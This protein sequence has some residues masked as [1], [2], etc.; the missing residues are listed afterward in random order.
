M[1][2]GEVDLSTA[3]EGV[4]LGDRVFIALWRLG[5]SNVLAVA[6]RELGALL[7]SPV[8]WVVA[9]GFTLI[10]AWVGFIGT[11]INGQQAS[12]EGVFSVITT[13]VLPVLAP[14]ITM[15][16][17][18]QEMS[19]GTLE[20]LLATP[21]RNWELTIGKWL[22]PFV[23]Y[24]L[25]LATTLVYLG[26]L[27]IYAPVKQ[28]INVGPLQFVIGQ[29]DLGLVVATYCGLL[30]V[31]AAAV[32]IGVLTSSLT[33]SQIAAFFAAL[34][35]VSATWYL[36]YFLGLFTQPPLS[37]VFQYVSAYNRYQSFSLG[38]VT[39]KDAIFFGTLLIGSLF[40]TSRLLES[41]R[42]R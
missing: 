23:F 8:G 17:F 39:L 29:L 19:G 22:G 14:L 37:R 10:V 15:R 3:A 25:L 4:P 18:A 30:L 42:W 1:T 38:Q 7:V 34:A 12:V 5:I 24:V 31:G 6:T 41:R 26:L 2:A 40:V 32:A 36:G 27:L 35:S 11:D 20:L 33:R 9:V 13:V 21:V 16:L 28:I